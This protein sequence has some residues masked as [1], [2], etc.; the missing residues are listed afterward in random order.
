MFAIRLLRSLIPPAERD[1]VVADLER[2]YRERV[3][4][5]GRVAAGRWL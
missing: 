1:E 5:G 3:A 4:L 2:E